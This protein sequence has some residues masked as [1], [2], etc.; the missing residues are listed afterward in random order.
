MKAIRLSTIRHPAKIDGAVLY[1]GPA[2]DGAR[3]LVIATGL[4]KASKNPKTGA[5]VQTW[6]IRADR[7]PV[8][9]I[10][11]GSDVTICFTCPHRKDE[12]GRRVCYVN[13]I[14]PHAIFKAWKAG[15][16]PAMSP[17]EAVDH[18]RDGRPW[19]FGSYGDPAAA[20]VGLW[21]ALADLVPG[22]TGYT[23]AWRSEPGLR[24]VC[25]AS[26][27]NDEERREAQSLGWRTF[28]V[29][30]EV[31]DLTGITCPATPEGGS[32]TSCDSCRLCSGSMS[33]RSNVIPS[34]SVLVHGTGRQ[35]MMRAK[36]QSITIG[37]TS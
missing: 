15:K 24:S 9:A 6:I 1:D 4:R 37:A 27:D 31:E 29:S 17:A 5:M 13:P 34:V 22:H 2:P 19:R 7:S 12:N 10:H 18:A 36:T 35:R 25:M 30:T 23:H 26:V 28:S 32:R 21:L 8:E 3:I 16:Y 33:N 11:D 20:P 14:G